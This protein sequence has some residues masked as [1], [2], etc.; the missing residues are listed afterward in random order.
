MCVCIKLI[1]SNLDF[2]EECI[3]IVALSELTI[4][5]GHGF[6]HPMKDVVYIIV[7]RLYILQVRT[8]RV[9]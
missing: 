6:G 3:Y 5:L 1:N 4:L 9:T 7:H 8:A 2:N